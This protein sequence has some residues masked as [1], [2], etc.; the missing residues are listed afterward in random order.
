MRYNN[1][2]KNGKRH[3]YKKAGWILLGVVCCVGGYLALP[4]N[5]YLRRALTHF[6][7][8][9]DQYP[10]FENRV[11]KAEE[12]EP[13]QLSEAYNKL[14]IPTDYLPRFE[15]LGTVAYVIIQDSTLLFEQY[16]ED[17]SPQSLSNSFSMAKSIVSLAVGC[18][19]DEGYIESVDQQVRDFVP[20]FDGFGGK[21]LT[22][23]HLLTMSAGVDF[24]EAYSSPFSPTTQLYYGNDLRKIAFGMK[25]TEE[26][27]VNFVY[28][29]GVTQLLAFVLERA[30]GEPLSTYVSR[31]LWTPMNAEEDA[32]WSLDR[33]DGTEK[34]YCCF[35][36]NARDFARFG[37]LILNEGSWNGRQLVA[38]AYLQEATAPDTSLTFKEFQ[39]PNQCYGF[40]FWSLNYKGMQIPYMRGILGQYVFVIP[41]KN[42]V[43]VRLGHKRS[44]TRSDQHYPDDIDTWLGAAIEMMQ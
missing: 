19:I 27:G 17:Y 37:Q 38:S 44:D 18:A 36:S 11:V 39:E 13:W 5:Y 20:G 9:I 29:S 43:V 25:E 33:K 14:E 6:M 28:Q 35:N 10:I 24:Q 41:E 16:W 12:P 23:R 40:Q 31:K 4:S 42:A 22:L 2:E 34:A 15:E 26:P 7:P 21:R 8:K 32:L 1:N 3:L 30:V